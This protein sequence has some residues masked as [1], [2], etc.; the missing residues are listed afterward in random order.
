M[1][2]EARVAATNR[3]AVKMTDI[4]INKHPLKKVVDIYLCST[5]RE[6]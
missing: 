3:F 4:K 6:S 2:V 1:S 5:D